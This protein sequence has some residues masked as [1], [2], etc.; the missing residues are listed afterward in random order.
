MTEISK[1]RMD[2]D[3]QWNCQKNMNCTVRITAVVNTQKYKEVI[4]MHNL[5][6]PENYTPVIDYMESQ[7]A[8]KKIKDCKRYLLSI[9]KAAETKK[10]ALTIQAEKTKY[11]TKNVLKKSLLK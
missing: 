7:R 9:E 2:S 3:V 6:I 11:N 8:I 4:A 10:V 1:R 5:L